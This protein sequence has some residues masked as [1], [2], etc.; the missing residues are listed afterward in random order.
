MAQFTDLETKIK[1]N[2]Q[3]NNINKK[4]KKF[5]GRQLIY[6][7]DKDVDEEGEEIKKDFKPK[8]KGTGNN[9]RVFNKTRPQKRQYEKHSGTGRGKESAKGGAGGKTVWG[10]NPE[11]IARQARSGT[12]DDFCKF[13]KIFQISIFFFSLMKYF[14]FRKISQIKIKNN[15]FK[16]FIFF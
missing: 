2:M 15:F 13:T 7:K 10:D 14:S 6:D 16:F 1:V 9:D 11:Q 3:E 12:R 5:S 4:I 8:H